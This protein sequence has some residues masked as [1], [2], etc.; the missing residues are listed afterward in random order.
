MTAFEKIIYLFL[1]NYL[2]RIIFTKC[3]YNDE[4]ISSSFFVCRKRTLC[5]SGYAG[6][7]VSSIGVKQCDG[8]A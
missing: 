1:V 7:Q 8:Y 4:D 6:G 3:W 5:G 2:R